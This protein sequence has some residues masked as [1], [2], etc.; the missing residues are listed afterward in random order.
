MSKYELGL[1]RI[2][3][4]DECKEKYY[5]LMD[6]LEQ[7]GNTIYKLGYKHNI[8][9]PKRIIRLFDR[10]FDS[11]PEKEFMTREDFKWI[12]S[13]ILEISKISDT[14]EEYSKIFGGADFGSFT[15]FELLCLAKDLVGYGTY[16]LLLC[17]DIDN[18]SEFLADGKF[19][20]WETSDPDTE[21]IVDSLDKLYD[22]LKENYDTED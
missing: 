12:C 21:I 8:G 16:D 1:E 19:S 10:I 2:D 17:P 3:K 15:L 11:F 5:E 9:K 14:L 7:F 4:I 6:G 13:E 22:F 18:V 20:Y